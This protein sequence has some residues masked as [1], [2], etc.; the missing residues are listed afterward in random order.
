M[1]AAVGRPAARKTPLL[2]EML[3]PLKALEEQAAVAY[4][5]EK[6]EY[7]V[8][9]K[10]QQLEA[11]SAERKAKNLVN[12]GKHQEAQALLVKAQDANSGPPLRKRFTVNDATV[13]KLHELHS[14][15]PGGL[16]VY[17]DELVGLL[18]SL[19][20]EDKQTDRAF[21][22]EAWNGNINHISDRIGRGTIE[23]R[24]A[25]ISVLGGIQPAKLERYLKSMR[26]GIDDDGLI[27][28]LQLLVYPDLISRQPV[29]RKPNVM[30][31]DEAR[32]VF[33][34]LDTLPVKE[35][36]PVYRLS[37]AGQRV[38]D[39]WYADH[40]EQCACQEDPHFEAHLSKYASLLPSIT[41]LI[42][43]AELEQA[44]D[45]DANIVQRAVGWCDYLESHARR[46]YALG[47]DPFIGARQLLK[48]LS[49]L[50]QPFRVAD[51]NNRR[52]QSLNNAKDIQRAL[53]ALVSHGYLQ[54][55]V[56]PTATKPATY[57]HIHPEFLNEPPQSLR[58]LNP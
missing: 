52:W 4:E 36:P 21:F 14:Q 26:S 23:L 10:M 53:N 45:I 18:S 30:A 17:R 35:N 9:Q 25:A 41:L 56:I 7:K 38:F 32:E 6:T 34:S 39:A 40:L 31:R 44:R 51:F 29:D 11:G 22:L 50:P 48:N 42:H 54:R 49:R 47:Q 43:L 28:R 8:R 27:Q 24:H 33:Q 46:V 20:R 13:E 57:Y 55:Q 12:Q 16:L 5:R 37:E 3:R 58:Q 15:N 2:A 19:Q 1:G